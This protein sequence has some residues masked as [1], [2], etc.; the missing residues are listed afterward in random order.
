MVKII[1]CEG[2]DG[3]GKSTLIKKLHQNTGLPIHPRAVADQ[4]GE[5]VGNLFDWAR[6]D[7]ETWDNQP[8]SLYDRHPFVSEYIYGPITRGR[9]APGF[10]RGAAKNY[11]NTFFSE[12]LLI[13]CVTDAQTIYENLKRNDQMDG[14]A[15]HAEQLIVAYTEI[16]AKYP[17]NFCVYNYT[18]D[19]PDW[20]YTRVLEKV[21]DYINMKR[22]I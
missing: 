1:V 18:G 22:S 6:T 3:T 15:E 10:R 21:E 17:G 11:L 7:V 4:T 5:P 12:A 9:V 14:V 20:N 19:D 13:F 16:I 8:L 2:F